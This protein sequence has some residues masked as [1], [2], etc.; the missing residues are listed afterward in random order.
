MN[1]LPGN[2]ERFRE[3]YGAVAQAFF[4]L[5]VTVH[6]AGPLDEKTEE[7]V[8]LGLAVGG[9]HEGGVHSHTRKALSAG[10]TPDEIRHVVVLAIPTL[11]FPHAMAAM[12]WVEDILSPGQPVE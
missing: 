3:R 11:G 5:G 6:E 8:Q 12:S 10:A 7:L 4:N 2:Y 1:R 9:H